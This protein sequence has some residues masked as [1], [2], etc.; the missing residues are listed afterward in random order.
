MTPVKDGAVDSTGGGVYE[1]LMR[2]TLPKGLRSWRLSVVNLLIA[3]FL[4]PVLFAALPNAGLSA[5]AALDRDIAQ[6]Y[7][8]ISGLEK[9][10]NL[11][12]DHQK[13]DCCICV[14]PAS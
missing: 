12:A 1:Q 13:H 11:P 6:S 7:C 2:G 10:D 4:V 14:R 8:D 5:A 9:S 3:A